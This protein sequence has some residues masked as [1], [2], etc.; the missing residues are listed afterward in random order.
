MPVTR[1]EKF[2]IHMEN[3]GWDGFVVNA[4]PS[5]TYLSGMHFHLMERPVVMFFTAEGDP[6]IIL[7]HLEIPK[8]FDLPYNVSVHSYEENP[9]SWAEV[10]AAALKGSG[11]NKGA[12]IG[13]EPRQ[14]RLLEYQ[15]LQTA[16]PEI[17]YLDGSTLIAELRSIKDAEEISAMTKAV[18]IAESALEETLSNVKIGV[19]E[20][21]IASELF[22]QLLGHGS[23][24]SLPFAPMVA[25]GPNGANPHARPSAR[26]LQS[27]DLL[28]IDWGACYDGYASDLTRTFAVGEPDQEA[29]TIYQLVRRANRIG[30]QAGKAGVCCGAVDKATRGVIEQGGYGQ[31]FTHRTGHGIGMECHEEPYIYGGNE[32]LLQIGNTYT[33]EPGIYLPGKNGVRIEDNLLVRQ[34]STESLSTMSRE[35]RYI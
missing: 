20:K 9:E 11:L 16:V 18:K 4:G 24:S 32:K 26:K 31:F 10:F 30:R 2:K 3:R 17:E 27:G 34:D 8:L 19:T 12:K 1:I 23:E 22:L 5:L 6:L 33:V 15:L 28:I 29:L 14:L 21:E 7:P 35:L 25:A 13:I